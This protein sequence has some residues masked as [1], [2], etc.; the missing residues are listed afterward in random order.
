VFNVKISLAS[1]LVL[2]AKKNMKSVGRIGERA[3]LIGVVPVK[4]SNFA[5]PV[6]MSRK[7]RSFIPALGISSSVVVN[8]WM[9]AVLFVVVKSD[10]F[11][12]EYTNKVPSDS[13]LSLG[14]ALLK[15]KLK[16][17]ILL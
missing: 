3:N 8:L 14:L 4:G 2:T 12:V 1:T 13:V 10:L 16:W 11:L 7:W 6:S 17:L 9:V 15:G 5:R